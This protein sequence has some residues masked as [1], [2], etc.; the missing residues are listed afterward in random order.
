MKKL[1]IALLI[2]CVAFAG[3][4]TWKNYTPAEEAPVVKTIDYDAMFASHAPDEV[5]MTVDGEEVTW[6]TYFYYLRS[7]IGNMD[8]LFTYYYGGEPQWGLVADETTGKT[9]GESMSDLAKE[10]ILQLYGIGRFAEENGGEITAEQQAVLDEEMKQVAERACGEGATD[11]DFN[12]YLKTIYANRELYD[13]ISRISYLI[14]S[15]FAKLY[16]ENGE[17]ISD[18]DAAAYIEDNGYAQFNHILFMCI[19]PTTGAALDE[20]AQAEKL[21]QAEA[22]AEELR[23]AEST[24]ELLALYAQRKEELDEDTG[25]TAYPDGY[26]VTPDAPYVPE[27]LDGGYALADYEVSDPVKSS[28]GYHV[29]LRLP[30]TIDTVLDESTGDNARSL[31]AQE[32]YNR[33]LSEYLG[34]VKCEFAPGFV[35]V[36]V[37]DYV[38][39]Q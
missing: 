20:T 13:R 24:E 10:D 19:D 29:M 21:K 35:P 38:K 3:F 17:L 14:D 11:E 30:V 4:L 31:K 34:G 33:S 32:L 2:V 6:E 8:S 7:E 39:V 15:C 27:F 16:G 26:I 23:A 9:I 37:E 1:L 22:L 28:Y 12:A 5:V 18:E 25:K 36:N